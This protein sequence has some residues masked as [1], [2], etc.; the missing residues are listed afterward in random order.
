MSLES[1]V[2]WCWF[3]CVGWDEM[4]CVRAFS[5]VCASWIAAYAGGVQGHGGLCGVF[6]GDCVCLV[7]W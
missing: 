6:V 4:S 5:L 3:R 1:K 7:W 2:A